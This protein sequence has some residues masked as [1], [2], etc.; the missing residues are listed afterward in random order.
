MES[1]WGDLG[2]TAGR[3]GVSFRGDERVLKLD[4]GIFVQCF[5]YAK[6]HFELYALSG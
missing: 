4:C 3:N 2:M 6:N 5:Q 1:S